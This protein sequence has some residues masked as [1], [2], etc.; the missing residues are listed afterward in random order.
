MPAEPA[1]SPAPG[2]PIDQ[3]LEAALRDHSAG[4]SPGF[5]LWHTTLR[6]QREV[7]SA[8][9]EVSLTHVQF[10]LLASTWW[11]GRDGD[12]PNQRQVAEHAGL[13]QVMT[14]QVVRT[15]ER[16]LLL[17][18]VRSSTDSRARELELTDE[19]QLLARRAV[20]LMDEVDRE[21]FSVARD[22]TSLVEDLR[23]LAAR[24]P[25]GEPLQEPT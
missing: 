12:R 1:G 17:R 5:M 2:E 20:A 10:L 16:N 11:L 23:N 25:S 7:A 3:V 21:F 8:L 9:R 22:I 6:W 13:D 14:S 18:R 4:R 15:L 19:G 24:T